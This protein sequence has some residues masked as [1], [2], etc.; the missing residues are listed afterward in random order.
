MQALER[1]KAEQRN[2]EWGRYPVGSHSISAEFQVMQVSSRLMPLPW[3]SGT[4]GS[5]SEN[6]DW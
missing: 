4:C 3:N 1:D 6:D 5:G 2:R